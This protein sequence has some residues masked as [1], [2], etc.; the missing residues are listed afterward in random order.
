MNTGI[1][2]KK[3]RWNRNSDKKPLALGI[4]VLHD[5]SVALC[6]PDGII[7]ALA[8]ERVSRIKH[9]CG[10]PHQALDVLLRTC[11]IGSEDIDMIAFATNRVLYPRHKNTHV[12]QAS[13]EANAV[14]PSLRS[15]IRTAI[16]HAAAKARPPSLGKWDAFPGRHWSLYEDR[17]ANLG[18]MD[19]RIRH[20]YVAHHRAHAA[21]AFRLSGFTD[22]CVLTMDGTGNGLSG[23]IS[24]GHPDGR[25]ELL[26]KSGERDS[27]G[28]FYQAVTEALGFIPVD[29]EYKTMG[30]AAFGNANVGENPFRGMVRVEDG[31]LV[32]RIPWTLRVYNERHPE[33][34][35]PNPNPS[36]AQADEFAAMLGAISREQFSAYAQAHF[37]DVMLAYAKDGMRITGS[38]NLACA[39]GVM[40]NVK[41]NALIRDSLQPERYFVFPDSGDSGLAA[42]AAMEALYQAG[43]LHGQATFE[44]AYLGHEYP[45]EDIKGDLD[46]LSKTHGLAVQE[47]DIGLVVDKLLEG[48]VIGTFQ[49]RSEMGPR[50]L[51]NRSVI[52]DPRSIKVKDHINAILKGREWFV[53]FAP[54]VLD[55]DAHKL[56][57]GPQEYPYMTFAV[58]ASE[59]AKQTVPAIVHTDGT[60]R[61]QVVTQHSNP[62]FY[63]VLKEFKKR[64]GIGVLLNTSFN[65]HGLPIVGTPQDAVDHLVNGWVEGLSIGQWFVEKQ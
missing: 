49:G 29:G 57:D 12:I 36:V 6:S 56:W 51:G 41:A 3:P 16:M 52:A 31:R 63:A 9:H 30:L 11:S 8:E 64:T 45:E 15:R 38:Q 53:P 2:L 62:W 46:N 47:A 17:L 33:K 28:S 61:P 59:Y 22:A 4:G 39:G 20:Y 25:L 65:R 10:F 13:G 23:T 18:F 54:S 7:F 37:E 14:H 50:A 55:E 43:A 32:S 24:R 40:L 42:G 5:A 44:H 21:S 26:R 34:N 48:R 58:N 19:K 27:I 35:L 1:K 60:M